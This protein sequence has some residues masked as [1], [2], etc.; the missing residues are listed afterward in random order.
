MEI[1]VHLQPTEAVSQSCSRKHFKD[2]LC[3]LDG[4]STN[5]YLFFE[6]WHTPAVYVNHLFLC[7]HRGS[8]VKYGAMQCRCTHLGC[9]DAYCTITS[10]DTQLLRA[11]LI[12][13]ASSN[14][15]STSSCCTFKRFSLAPVTHI[16]REAKPS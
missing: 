5:S 11:Y 4:Y 2:T 7:S 9:S 16:M 13:L 3:C 15:I 12:Q 8:N 10:I 1:L 14:L 6:L